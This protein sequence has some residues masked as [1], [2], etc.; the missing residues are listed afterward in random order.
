MVESPLLRTQVTG[1]GIRLELGTWSY[2]NGPD[3]ATAAD[4]LL[5]RL[6]MLAVRIRRGEFSCARELGPPDNDY[7]EFLWQVGEIADQPDRLRALVFG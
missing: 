2:G 6:A 3:L 7:L 1:G 4:D 5:E